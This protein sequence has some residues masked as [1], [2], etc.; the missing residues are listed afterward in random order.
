[1]IVDN[2]YRETPALTQLGTLQ[3]ALKSNNIEVSLDDLDGM[4]LKQYKYIWALIYNNEWDK[5]YKILDE[6]KKI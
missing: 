1:M 5:L 6:L 4:S 3:K 2:K